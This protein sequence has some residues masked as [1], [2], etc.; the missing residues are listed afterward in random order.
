MKKE[1]A[2]NKIIIALDFDTID[3]A[4]NIVDI[5]GDNI[6]FYK[7]GLEAYLNYG[8]DI[9]KYLKE[10]NKKIFLDLKFNDIPN[11]TLKACEFAF[12]NNIDITTVH[13]TVGV[14]VINKI[15]NLNKSNTLVAYVTV[16][17]SFSEEK[18]NETFHNNLK[19][20]EV[21]K[22]MIEDISKVGGRAIICSAHEAKIAKSIDNE[23][24]TICPGV[25]LSF[26]QNDQARIVTPS[27]AFNNGADYIV[28]GREVTLSN[29]PVS[30]LEN[31][32]KDINENCNN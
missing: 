4:K 32:Y 7:V 21:I 17:T 26:S 14:E 27:Q 30:S 22:L 6:I 13:Y 12:K 3:K 18:Y 23:I 28:I 9:I 31:I 20:N 19:I 10:K 29:D 24:K 25:R 5:L 15:T 2:K 1:Q 11:T 8:T 16:L